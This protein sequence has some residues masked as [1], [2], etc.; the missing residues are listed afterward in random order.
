MLLLID[1]GGRSRTP[2]TD[3]ASTAARPS[4][5]WTLFPL[6]NYPPNQATSMALSFSDGND[7]LVDKVVCWCCAK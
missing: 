5:P 7:G 1:F 4:L 3:P 6:T 2:A